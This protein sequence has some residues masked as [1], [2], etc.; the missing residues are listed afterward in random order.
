MSNKG[1][2]D[3]HKQTNIISWTLDSG[4]TYHMINNLD[5]LSDVRECNEII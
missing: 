2:N 1:N 3:N 5:C 4:T